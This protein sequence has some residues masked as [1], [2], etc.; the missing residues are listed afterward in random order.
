M[1]HTVH[2]YAHRLGILRDWRSRWFADKKDFKTLLRSDV[3]LREYLVKKLRTMHVSSV[4]IERGSKSSRI[5]IA[6]ARPGLII[7]RSGEGMIKIKTDL[8][9]YM[10]RM[11]LGK[12]ADF[13][14]DI[15]EVREPEADAK[16]VALMVVEGLEKR[17]P[18]RRV[19][20]QTLEKVMQNRNVKGAKI[21]IGGRLGGADMARTEKVLKGNIPLQ[22]LRA[23]IDFARERALM[24]YGIIGIKVWIYKGEIFEKDLAQKGQPK[25]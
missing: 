24:T 16:I 13:K 20:K 19:L 4:E 10:K 9:K 6:T 2:P 1:P 22:T 5:I 17:F 18:F 23:D 8:E 15:V 21:E 7:G 14:I 3:F 25:K 12:I 11:K